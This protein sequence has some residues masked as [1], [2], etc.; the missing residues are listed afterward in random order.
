MSVVTS[1]LPPKRLLPYNQTA[2][3]YTLLI[4]NLQLH[5]VFYLHNDDM[6]IINLN[7]KLQAR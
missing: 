6:L 5:F 1:T 7:D 4:E 3:A 2:S